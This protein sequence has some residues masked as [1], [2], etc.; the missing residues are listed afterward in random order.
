MKSLSTTL[1]AVSMFSIMSGIMHAAPQMTHVG[2]AGSEVAL[3]PGTSPEFMSALASFADEAALSAL[4]PLLPYCVLVKNGSG[5]R[6]MA[7]LVRYELTDG[8]GRVV[9]HHFMLGTIK[10]EPH[11]MIQP[12]AFVLITPISGLNVL[13]QPG[14][15]SVGLQHA[16]ELT[17]FISSTVDLYSKQ[18]A[19]SVTLDSVAFE[20]GTLTGPDKTKN[21]ERIN[22]WIRAEKDVAAAL[23]ARR[24][25]DV[26]RYLSAI[27]ESPA[28]VANSYSEIDHF[29]DH[30][31]S[32]A[33]GLLQRFDAH[34]SVDALLA[35]IG[36]RVESLTPELKRKEIR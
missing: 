16:G 8:I 33:S 19:I 24:G 3:L 10:R 23:S 1:A 27:L 9:P 12:G 6:L 21:L 17:Y 18:S 26:V 31:R 15:S 2:I 28:K 36:S 13:L 4:R 25:S 35:E 32:F 11:L 34:K 22:A 14:R 29:E 5:S 30:R 7:I 20:E